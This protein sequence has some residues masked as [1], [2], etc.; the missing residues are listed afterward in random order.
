MRARLVKTFDT[1]GLT[2]IMLRRVRAERIGAHIIGIGEEREIFMRYKQVLVICNCAHRAIAFPDFNRIVTDKR[3][4]YFAAMAAARVTC[5][6]RII[7]PFI[8]KRR[9]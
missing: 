6:W 7:G 5:H 4:F 2:K 1:A 3:K 8:A 9:V